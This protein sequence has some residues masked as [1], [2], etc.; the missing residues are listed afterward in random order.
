MDFK[1]SRQLKMKLGTE[2]HICILIWN[3]FFLSDKPL[4]SNP[5]IIII[6]TLYADSIHNILR[7]SHFQGVQY[8]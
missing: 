8:L 2:I 6:Y 3:L 7:A 4:F 1:T 5:L